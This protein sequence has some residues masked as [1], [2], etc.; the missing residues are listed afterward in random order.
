M[1]SLRVYEYA[2]CGTCVKAKK[3]LKSKEVDFQE[4]PIVDTP[5]S[6]DDLKKML[7][8]LKARG[9]KI[10]KLFNTSGVLYKEM[11]LSKK[12]PG[13]SEDESLDLLAQHGKLIKRPFVLM[14]NDGVV[15][16]NEEEWKEK[17]LG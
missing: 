10:N 2:K 11:E 5:P 17:V 13:M 4:I 16:F 14:E 1:S 3:F 7:E 6:R 15:G 12:L 9:Q 8:Y